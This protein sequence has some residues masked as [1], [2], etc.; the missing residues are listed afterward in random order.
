[1]NFALFPQSCLR[2][3][4]STASVREADGGDGVKDGSTVDEEI[5]EAGLGIRGD[6]ESGGGSTEGK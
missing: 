6:N 2:S 3:K 4:E 5:S 1:M